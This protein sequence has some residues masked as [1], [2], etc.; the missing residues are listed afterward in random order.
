MLRRLLPLMAAPQLHPCG[1]GAAATQ[2]WAGP[3]FGL[4]A[5]GWPYDVEADW[6]LLTTCNFRCTYCFLSVEALSRPIAPPA[7]AQQLA[8][9]F[10]STRL[11]WLLHL[12]GGEPFH[13]PDF[14]E[15]C[16]LL[17]QR[18]VISINT[19]ADSRR[20]PAFATSID[21]ARVDFINCGIHV[22][23]RLARGRT[24]QFVHNVRSL[25]DA[26][27]DAFVSCVM[28]PNVFSDFPALWQQYADEGLPIIPKAFRGA[29]LGRR[30]PE[31]YSE[32]E[33]SLFRDY[34]NRAEAA[35]A[36]QI[37]GR[38]ARPSID[39]LLDR[40]LFLHGVADSRGQD[41][42]AGRHFVRIQPD[43]AIQRCGPADIIGNVVAGWFERREGP[44]PCQE[45]ECPYFCEKYRVAQ[46]ALGR[47]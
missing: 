6:I 36:D 41:C 17:T 45:S 44:S 37:S 14:L 22:E 35:Y 4:S 28:H 43:G 13:Y 39:P 5:K 31:A 21:P 24:R 7:S 15:L 12:T 40:E 42:H 11:R 38:S 29:H 30:Y 27:F 10:D 8:S 25:R 23:Q 20:I 26:G 16:H 9:F 46:T 19:N 32:D 2:A 3:P 34:S 1:A 33:R 18:Q 47:S